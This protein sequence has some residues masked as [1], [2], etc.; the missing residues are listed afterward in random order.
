M[1]PRFTQQ[2]VLWIQ[3]AGNFGNSILPN[4]EIAYTHHLAPMSLNGDPT[5]NLQMLVVGG[6]NRDGSLWPLTTPHQS[7]YPG[8][9]DIYA[10]AEQVCWAKD[11]QAVGYSQT[12]NIYTS[13]GATSGASAQVAGLAAYFLGLP[14][15]QTYL[16]Q[17]IPSQNGQR[18]YTEYTE[19]LKEL[20]I[21]SAWSRV[22]YRDVLNIDPNTLNYKDSGIPDSLPAT[23]N[24]AWTA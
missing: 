2:G 17:W 15:T 19:N 12:S 3:A 18:D 9:I 24:Y 23:Y 4:G 6:V 10:Q 5:A 22:A 14:G 11:R 1:L 7:G 16:S 20:I 8:L 13:I 21:D